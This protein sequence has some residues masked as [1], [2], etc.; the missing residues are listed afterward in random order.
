MGVPSVSC[1]GERMMPI[2]LTS[3]TRGSRVNLASLDRHA[4]LYG[5]ESAFGDLLSETDTSVMPTSQPA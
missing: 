1:H 3:R 4:A 5:A 2:G